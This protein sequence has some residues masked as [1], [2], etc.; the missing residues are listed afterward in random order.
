MDADTMFRNDGQGTFATPGALATPQCAGAYDLQSLL[1]H[2]L[3]HWFGLNHS[4]V[5]R[6]IMFPF[7]PPPGNFL[8]SRPTAQTPDAQLGDDDRTGIRVLYAD[9]SD[10]LHTGTLRGRVLPAD[11]FALAVIPAPWT[12]RSVT[13]IFGA[14]VVAVDADTGAVV[15]GTFGGWSCD[16]LN[17]PVKFDRTY[18]LDHLAVGHNYKIY[19][20]PID[21]VV[22]PGDFAM[23][24]AELCGTG[25]AAECTTPA[26]KVNFST[27]T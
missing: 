24:V 20:E 16:V 7:A 25:A 4:A 11:P 10:A 2:E 27:R 6:V 13:G 8:G 18:E 22:G 19:A 5:W 26:V 3:G 21:G 1:T 15:A 23:A 12:G 17:P 9:P 14:Q